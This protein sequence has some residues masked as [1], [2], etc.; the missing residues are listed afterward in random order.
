MS[1][2][3]LA[4]QTL[5]LLLAWGSLSYTCFLLIHINIPFIWRKRCQNRSRDNYTK[6]PSLTI[7]ILIYIHY[8]V[9][10]W[11]SSSLCPSCAIQIFSAT[12][13]RCCCCFFNFIFVSNFHNSHAY[14]TVMCMNNLVCWC[15]YNAEA[16]HAILITVKMNAFVFMRIHSLWSC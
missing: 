4:I 11:I 8:N 14:L 5:T 12:G 15:L 1:C 3:L 7:Y 2:S 9:V 6:M 16:R 13:S 10:L